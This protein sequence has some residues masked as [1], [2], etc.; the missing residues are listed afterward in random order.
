[1]FLVP[2]HQPVPFD[3]GIVKGIA[4]YLAGVARIALNGV[5]AASV[6]AYH[7]PDVVGA[8]VQIPI[9]ENGVAGCDILIA[10]RSPLSVRGKPS[11]PL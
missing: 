9:K 3:T 11:N 6:C 4:L 8:S 5:N 2:I 7:K 10:P 1:M